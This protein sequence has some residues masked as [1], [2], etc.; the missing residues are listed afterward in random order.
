TI[1]LEEPACTIENDMID[2]TRK[3]RRMLRVFL[4]LACCGSSLGP[5]TFAAF[6]DV[7][8]TTAFATLEQLP[9]EELGPVTKDVARGG[10]PAIID[11]N[12]DGWLDVYVTRFGL[13]DVLI[14]NRNGL[15]ERVN[16]PL[17]IS[18]ADGGNVPVW[19]DFDNDGDKDMF[20]AV[21]EEKQHRF[22]LNSG[23]GIFVEVA[24]ERG[25]DLLSVKD[26]MGSGAAAGDLNRDGYLDIVVGEWGVQV[27]ATNQYEHYAV[28]MNKGAA[29]PGYF[30]NVT[31]ASG[32]DMNIGGVISFFAPTISDLDGDGWPDLPIV[33]D[34]HR[35]QLFWNNADGSFTNGTVEAG[36]SI[37]ENGM[38]TAIGDVNADG[39]L[40]WFV[41]SIR[42]TGY[43]GYFG[44]QLYIN[45]GERTFDSISDEVGVAVGGWGWG[46]DLFDYD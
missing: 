12:G 3:S 5:Q 8:E 35:S 20:V 2:R 42:F 31:E 11:F 33:A 40:D 6:T 37:E 26:H 1:D 38:G 39:L 18:T 19:A 44:N 43:P 15:F 16:N 24:E 4:L 17:G 7:T 30:T 32:V 13:E 45:Q 29:A 25:V 34:Y 23:G 36:V 41:T 28:Y 22:Y 21:A 14:I 10:T 27:D 9:I 46:C